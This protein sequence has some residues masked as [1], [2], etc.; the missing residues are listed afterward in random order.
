MKKGGIIVILL[1]IEE[2]QLKKIEN[3]LDLPPFPDKRKLEEIISTLYGIE[4][5]E[6]K[7]FAKISEWLFSIIA[8][9][10]ELKTSII[11]GLA[12]NNT[13]F[14]MDSYVDMFNQPLYHP[15]LSYFTNHSVEVAFSLSEKLAQFINV[16][17]DINKNIEE[18]TL[19]NFT[20]ERALIK[21][22]K[23]LQSKFLEPLKAIAEKR[24]IIREIR[25][26][27][28]HKAES[29]LIRSKVQI[30][31]GFINDKPTRFIIH[32]IEDLPIDPYQ[33]LLRSKEFYILCTEKISEIIKLTEEYLL[34]KYE[35]FTDIFYE[36]GAYKLAMGQYTSFTK[37]RLD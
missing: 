24:T 31:E 19:Y 29:E 6:T 14:N 32:G 33:T 13:E 11:Y 10:M 12:H 36:M 22:P 37:L 23:M 18:V 15:P 20:N 9:H 21:T 35:E 27:K 34:I 17:E 4:E 8:N 7:K 25:H 1:N 16:V 30:S 2:E 3:D 28:T 5:I 26:N